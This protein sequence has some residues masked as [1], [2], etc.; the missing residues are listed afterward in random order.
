M[1]GSGGAPEVHA[2]S[3]A[4]CDETAAWRIDWRNPRIHTGDRGK[5][6]LACDEH[7]EYLREFLA[8]RDFPLTVSALEI[9][10]DA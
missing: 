2:C 6:W 7:V 5:T 1:I 8:A 3:R 4:G 10:A 9:G